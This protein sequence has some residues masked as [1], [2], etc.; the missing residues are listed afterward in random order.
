MHR[1]RVLV[2]PGCHLCDA[3]LGVIE[4]VRA[5]NPFELEVVDISGD[6]DLEVRYRLDIP[7][8]EIDG[9]LAFTNFVTDEGLR[10]RLG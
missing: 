4:H 6:D 8:V 3:A 5:D 2:A 1:V 9:E 7:V 10:H